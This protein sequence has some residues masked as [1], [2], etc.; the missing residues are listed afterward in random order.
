MAVIN[1]LLIFSALLCLL[2]HQDTLAIVVHRL[3]DT[4]SSAGVDRAFSWLGLVHS[5]L[6]NRLGI[7][8]TGKL[9]FVFTPKHYSRLMGEMTV[10]LLDLL[11]LH[12][13]KDSMHLLSH[14]QINR[15]V[16]TQLNYVTF[17]KNT[18]K[19]LAKIINS[20]L[21]GCYKKK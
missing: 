8:K 2:P 1:Q 6:R 10:F 14:Q 13:H 11:A 17:C 4:A 21:L 15:A 9:V 19:T 20:C 3:T 5:K 18:C 12:K 16:R 7:V